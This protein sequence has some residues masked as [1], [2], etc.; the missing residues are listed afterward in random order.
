MNYGYCLSPKK[1]TVFFLSFFNEEKFRVTSVWSLKQICVST[2]L[3]WSYSYNAQTWTA[4]IYLPVAESGA[5]ETE[6]NRMNKK[7]K[8]WKKKPAAKTKSQRRQQKK[9][10]KS[11][12]P[13]SEW[14]SASQFVSKWADFISIS[15]ALDFLFMLSTIFFRFLPLFDI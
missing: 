15:W 5:K 4:L 6:K 14:A 13:Y 7:Q 1:P 12:T 8:Y 11:P 10:I 3:N 9:N 2:N